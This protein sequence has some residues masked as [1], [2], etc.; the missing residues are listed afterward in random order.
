VFG[1]YPETD[2]AEV[3]NILGNTWTYLARMPV[4]LNNVTSAF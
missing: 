1:S 4:K 3:Y 2:T